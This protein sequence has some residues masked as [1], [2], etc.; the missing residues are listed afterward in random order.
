MS[1][2]VLQVGAVF[3]FAAAATSGAAAII[4]SLLIAAG[5]N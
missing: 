5:V 3:A 4:L 2:R 1:I